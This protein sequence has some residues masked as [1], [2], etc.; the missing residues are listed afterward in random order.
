VAELNG[1]GRDELADPRDR[2]L[3][4][5]LDPVT[6]LDGDQP[7]VVDPGAEHGPSVRLDGPGHALLIEAHAPGTRVLVGPASRGPDGGTHRE[8]V[9]DGWRFVISV[10]SERLARLRERATSGREASGAGGRAE[11]R[12]VIPGRVVAVSVAVGDHVEAGQQVL[13]VE[14]MKMQNEVRAPHAGQVER[15][16]V[17]PGQAVEVGAVL[18]VIT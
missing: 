17:A 18:A 13:T 2:H 8:L 15:I 1:S 4:V 3:R 11:I 16:E 14:A 6:A 10:G 7:L 12:A 5:E 9:V